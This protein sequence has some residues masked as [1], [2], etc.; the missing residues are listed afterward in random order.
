[1]GTVWGRGDYKPPCKLVATL[2]HFRYGDDEL[3]AWG[4]GIRKHLKRCFIPLV[5]TEH[6]SGAGQFPVLLGLILVGL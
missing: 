6:L 2:G 3:E 4:V 1:M 5:F